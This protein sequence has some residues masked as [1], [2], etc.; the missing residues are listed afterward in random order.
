MA[1]W[2]TAGA[3]KSDGWRVWYAWPAGQRFTPATPTVRTRAGAPV[4]VT[5]GPWEPK[6]APTGSARQMAVREYRIAGGA[7]GELY[8][9]TIPEH[10]RTLFWR[11]L[12]HA[13]PERGSVNLL[14]GSCF[15][16]NDD[17]EGHY[18][19]AVRELVQREQPVLKLL[20]GDQLYVDVPWPTQNP[21]GNIRRALAARYEEYWGDAAY[22]EVLAACPTLVTCD[23]HEFWNDYPEFQVHV[24]LSWKPGESGSALAELYDAYQSALNPE[25]RR[26]FSFKIDP[27]S[28]FVADT[29]SNRSPRREYPL[30]RPGAPKPGQRLMLDDQW[31]ALERWGRSLTGP[32][33][34]VLPQP[35]LKE[36]GSRFDLTLVDFKDSDRLGGVFESVFRGQTEDGNPHDILILTGDIHTG[37]ISSAQIMGFSRGTAYELVA[38]PAS[39][40]TPWLP[41]WG[42]KPSKLPDKLRVNGKT[43]KV[44]AHRRLTATVDN[45]LG[46]V[47]IERGRNAKVRFSIQLWRIRPFTSAVRQKVF[48]R[49]PARGARPIHDPI[50]LELR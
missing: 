17:R 34:L 31:D 18:A 40:V 13:L 49:K 8:E 6:P 19:A 10:G 39:R 32:G 41:P 45:N 47:R 12:P 27:V 25:G 4:A 35:L 38:S 20:M 23:D 44:T 21:L 43:W 42:A 46:L 30:G 5:P 33:V 3:P 14:I 11:T 24:P 37:R 26:W 50:E 22:R 2:V 28:F 7:P 16:I 1:V 29:R 36:G 15:W 9:V 48:G